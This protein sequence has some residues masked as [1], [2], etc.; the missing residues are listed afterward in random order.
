MRPIPL[1]LAITAAAVP[2]RAEP[3]EAVQKS[4]EYSNQGRHADAVRVLEEA[5][6]AEPGNEGIS[7]RLAT[8]LVFG[9]RTAEARARLEQL[10]QSWD[11]QVASMAANSLA[12]LDRAE[13]GE[14]AAKAK[15]PSAE[16]LRREREYAA[17]KA[18]LDRQQ[19]AY[20]LAAG[21]NDAAAI[22]AISRLEDEGEATPDLIRAKAAALDRLGQADEA[23]QVLRDLSL[24]A[25]QVEYERR[26]VDRLGGDL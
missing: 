6:A 7:F 5:A 10:R 24:K 16:Q 1:I 17:R 25:T 12:A 19:A 2:L 20:D 22:D 3:H 11:P 14:L 13:A 4:T 15:P 23:I 9:R 26:V 21:G 18:R 8:A